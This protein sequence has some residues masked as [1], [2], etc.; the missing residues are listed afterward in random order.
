VAISHLFRESRRLPLLII[1]GSAL[2]VLAVLNPPLLIAANTPTGGDMGAHVYAPLYLRDVLLP[3]GRV[4][5]WSNAWFGGFPAYYFYFPLPSLVIVALDLIVPYGVAFKLVT[6]AGLLGL[7]A[8]TYFLARSLRLSRTVAA[9]AASTGVAFVFMESYSIYGANIAS[10]LAGEFTFS[11]SFDLTLVYLGLL[12]KTLRDDRRYLPLTAVV[13]ALTALSHIITTIIVV[14]AS[15]PVLLWKKAVRASLV[16]WGW[17]F[18]LAGFWALPLAAR[19]G[20]SSDLAWTPLRAWEELFPVEIWLLLPAAIAGAVWTVRRT[21][22]VLPVL[23]FTLFPLIYY[24]LPVVLPELLPNLF[25]NPR[26]KLWNGRL[27]PYWYF[28]VTLFAAIALGAL[29]VWASRRLPLR[30]S[31]H[32]AR[33]L[34]VL[35]GLAAI[36]V[37]TQDRFPT[38]APFAAGAVFAMGI[39]FSFLWSDRVESRDF[40]AGAAGVAIAFGALAGLSFVSGWA[41]WNYEGYEG[42]QTW[43]EYQALMQTVAA[44]PPGRVLWEY[45]RDMDKYGTPMALML[46]PLWTDG[47]H[48]SMEGLFFESSLS[49]PFH[50]LN[51]AEMSD[52]PSQPVPGLNYHRFDFD[53]GIAHL[54]L[55]NVRYYVTFTEQAT[56]EARNRPELTEVTSSPPFTVFELPQSSLVDVATFVPAVY[57]PPSAGGPVTT[58]GRL[59]SGNE[60]PP[61]AT[62]NELALD[63]YDDV[64][65]LDH[66]VVEDGPDDWPRVEGV[67]AL[68]AIPAYPGGG[69]V[70]DVTIDNHRITFRTTAVGV[71]HLVKVSYFPNWRAEGAE[72]PYRASPSLMVVIPEQ[73]EV[74]LEFANTWAETAGNGLTLAGLIALAAIPLL[75]RRGLIAA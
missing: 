22:R 62:F 65:L 46:M 5:G 74:T 47:T 6:V 42:K 48:P 38:W 4:L 69:R 35:G 67:E 51:Q 20:F 23:T 3:A 17:G 28:G 44:L 70:S 9:V 19:I 1:V 73:E 16:I 55:Y 75:K 26:W 11:W 63:W 64:T 2:L 54:M 41:K 49:T 14:I 29:M 58:I 59:L 40:L 57:D 27:L 68:A 61:S 31:R 72:G 71:P 52:A 13:L 25:T 43:P 30:I 36:A 32:W 10:T 60:A 56:I 12:I 24:P 21:P 45:H 37:T 34:A 18:A 15:L 7:P 33:G 8:A 66:W 53:R 50:F 39:G